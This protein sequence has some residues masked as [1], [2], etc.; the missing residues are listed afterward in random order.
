MLWRSHLNTLIG[1]R[2]Q[3]RLVTQEPWRPCLL[4]A[5][6]DCLWRLF[7]SCSRSS[8]PGQWAWYKSQ[9]SDMRLIS[10]HRSEPKLC[11]LRCGAVGQ[12]VCSRYTRSTT[13]LSQITAIDNGIIHTY[14]FQSYY[15]E[16]NFTALAV[17]I[18]HDEQRQHCIY[19][20]MNSVSIVSIYYT[21][22][23]NCPGTIWPF[24]QILKLKWY[25]IKSNKQ[26]ILNIVT[27]QSIWIV[28][29]TCSWISF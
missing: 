25:L 29:Y 10:A 2:A 15:S 12:G 5:L 8:H 27:L 19:Y 13:L 23:C 14:W 7:L 11:I 22:T 18:L 3:R 6:P 26:L 9:A 24:P 20:T 21:M 17:H 28:Q 1:L 16:I 4:S